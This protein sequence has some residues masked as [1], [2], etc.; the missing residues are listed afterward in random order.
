MTRAELKMNY[1][2]QARALIARLEEVKEEL[3]EPL[4]NLWVTN[5]LIKD[6]STEQDIINDRQDRELPEIKDRLEYL[7]DSLFEPDEETALKMEEWG[8][9]EE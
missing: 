3:K 9:R 5:Q 7:V 8:E 6:I 2:K 1:K 4:Y